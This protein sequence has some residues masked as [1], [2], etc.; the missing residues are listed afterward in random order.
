MIFDDVAM[1][2]LFEW[3]GVVYRRQPTTMKRSWDESDSAYK[4][5]VKRFVN[6]QAVNLDGKVIRPAAYRFFWREAEI[7]KVIK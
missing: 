5:L 3:D 1:G 4:R 2:G 7:D 6:A